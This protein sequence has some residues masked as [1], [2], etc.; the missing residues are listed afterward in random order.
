MS[1]EK[2][3]GLG[4]KMVTGRTKEQ[5]ARV[6]TAE[7]NF[8]NGFGNGRD[9]KDSVQRKC[10]EIFRHMEQEGTL[11]V[12]HEM[13]MARSTQTEKFEARRK[14][15][16]QERQVEI[17]QISKDM[18]LNSNSRQNFFQQSLEHVLSP[19]RL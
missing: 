7:R 5:L 8:G 6:Q 12:R 11:V 13:Q 16:G 2:Q 10:V 9:E 19:I 14:G 15:E 17:S 3:R 18:Q 1:L 4:F